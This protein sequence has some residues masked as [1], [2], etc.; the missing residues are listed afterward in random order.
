M[1]SATSRHLRDSSCNASRLCSIVCRLRYA[2]P[3][4][5]AKIAS[6]T[7]SSTRVKP[8]LGRRIR[9][10][11]RDD[12]RGIAHLRDGEVDAADRGV[13]CLAHRLEDD[14]LDAGLRRGETARDRRR[15]K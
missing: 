10:E 7:S 13:G 6:A 15:Q 5:I 4:M 14:E 1:K 11:R 12:A 9:G 3:L 8:R 2:K